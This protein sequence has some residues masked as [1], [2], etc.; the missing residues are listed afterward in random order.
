MG[1]DSL[2]EFQPFT[3]DEVKN[4]DLVIKM[5]KYEDSLIHGSV[6]QQIYGDS[7]YKPRVSL[8]PEYTLHR[9]VLSE[10]GFTTSAQDV[11]NYRSIFSHYFRS[12][13]DYDQEVLSS[14]TYM[15]ENKCIYYKQP[16]IEIGD[17]L[18]NC[19]LY[20]LNGNTETNLYDKLGNDFRYMVV[21]GF[22]N[23]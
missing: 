8:F 1:K 17:Q 3:S 21:G 15:R 22:S 2:G 6:G 16:V 10:F 7:L 23:S 18:P 13:D 4:R 14:V 12:L 5:L 9:L 11:A 19:R 20:E